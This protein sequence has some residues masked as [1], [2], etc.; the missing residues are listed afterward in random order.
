M[1]E[2]GTVDRVDGASQS[3]GVSTATATD[4]RE[5][6]PLTVTKRLQRDGRWAEVEPV[7]NRMIKECRKKGMSKPD[8]QAWTYSELDRLYPPLETEGIQ[9]SDSE[10]A[11]AHPARVTGL[12][13]IPDHWPP[14]PSNAT[15][16]SEIQWVQASRIDVVEELPSGAV[17]V[18][19]DR[20]D[21][22][23]PSKAALGWLETSSR[24]YAKY[25]DIAAK[26]TNQPD[27][28]REHVRREK[29]AIEE[30]RSLLAEM[31]ESEPDANR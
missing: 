2:S 25:C 16:A 12:G 31:L 11:P 14:L 22:P 24:A 4:T 9:A 17:R 23:A 29:M 15:L 18:H 13:E 20:A 28:E 30:V 3:Q 5:V 21:R 10:I 8:A 27:N 1:D 19:L 7:R 26:A 6:D